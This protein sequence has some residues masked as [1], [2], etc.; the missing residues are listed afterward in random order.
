MDDE[1]VDQKI[2]IDQ[3]ND[4]L[5]KLTKSPTMEQ[6]AVIRGRMDTAEN[7]LNNFKKNIGEF[8]KKLK[9]VGGSMN[10]NSNPSS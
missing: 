7:L 3:L 9:K 1:L 8:E 4:T 10:S 6:F 5:F 2:L